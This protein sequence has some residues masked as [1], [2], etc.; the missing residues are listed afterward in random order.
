[1]LKHPKLVRIFAITWPRLW[2][3]LLVSTKLDVRCGTDD[4]RIKHFKFF[5]QI[6]RAKGQI[7]P[8]AVWVR[9]RFS[10]KKNEHFFFIYCEKQKSN[11]NKFIR[12]FLGRIYGTSICFRFYLTFRPRQKATKLDFQSEFLCQKSSKSF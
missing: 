11:Q 4:P 2:S 12:S 6:C 9:I 10:Q 1:M 3:I 8:K 5:L 7:K